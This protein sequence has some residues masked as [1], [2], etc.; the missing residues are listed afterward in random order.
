MFAQDDYVELPWS[1]I[2]Y[3]TSQDYC[4]LA[5]VTSI[6]YFLTC[7]IMI[8]IGSFNYT[9]ETITKG[10]NNKAHNNIIK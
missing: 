10:W 1:Y 8:V 2:Y 9:T 4:F 5:P 6:L 7:F 3:V